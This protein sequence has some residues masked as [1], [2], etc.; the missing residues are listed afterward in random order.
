M[1]F[2]NLQ[3]K[4]IHKAF[5]KKKYSAGQICPNWTEAVRIRPRSSEERGVAAA[6]EPTSGAWL[7][8]A[9]GDRI[10]IGRFRPS[11]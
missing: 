10:G 1:E 3:D 7:S 2:Q 5:S 8:A 11:D 4:Q 9:P 6:F